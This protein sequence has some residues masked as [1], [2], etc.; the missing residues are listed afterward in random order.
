MATILLVEDDA[1]LLGL[2]A[3]ML[4]SKGYAVLS[5][6]GGNEALAVADAHGAPVHLLVSDIV[7]PEMSG[8][9]LAR[10]MQTRQPQCRVLFLTGYPRSHTDEPGAGTA[11]G[12]TLLKP[13]AAETLTQM[14]GDILGA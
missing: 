11:R 6:P 7:M 1:P 8:H 12:P 3:E 5:A 2:V 9:E 14:V 10:R 4:R 13:F